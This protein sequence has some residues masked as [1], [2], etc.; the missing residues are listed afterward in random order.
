MYF[1]QANYNV[2]CEWGSEGIEALRTTCDIIIIVDVLSFSTCVDIAVSRNAIIYPY[3]YKDV[4]AAD[5]AD[6]V[7]AILAEPRGSKSGFSLSPQSLAQVPAGTKLVLP[8][9]NGATLTLL[10]QGVVTLAGCLRNARAIAAAAQERGNRIAVIPAGEQW[11]N[12]TLRVAAEDLI[13]AGAII[14]HLSGRKSPEAEV[15]LAAFERSVGNLEKVLTDCSSGRELLERG[16]GEDIRL[17]SAL[18]ESCCAPI[19][20]NGAYANA[21]I[22]QKIK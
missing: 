12:N 22:Q 6:S 8:S 21:L 14:S 17:A 16:F 20:Q 2:C 13:G 5:Y 19:F 15:A 1:S 4:S 3:R 10:T 9:P 18:D 11:S 7:Q